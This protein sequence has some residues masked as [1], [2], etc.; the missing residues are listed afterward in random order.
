MKLDR[1]S[2]AWLVFS[3]SIAYVALAI[4]ANWLASAYIVTVPF[5]HRL[6][7]A[8]VFAIGAILVL[9]D[10]LQQLAGLAATLFLVFIAAIV[11]FSAGEVFGWTDLRKIAVASL[12][13]FIVSETAEA[14]V[15][16]PI[17]RRSLTAGVALSGI[18]GTALDSWIFLS[19]AFGSLAFFW[20][21]CIGKGEMIA[22]GVAL[23]ALRRYALPSTSPATA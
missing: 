7:P 12:V 22:V 21:Q 23:T 8:G 20:G 4:L 3:L 13:A 19:L 17:R 11:S 14:V 16:T 9:R 5:T 6:A 10:W 15:F 2:K 1:T 18:V